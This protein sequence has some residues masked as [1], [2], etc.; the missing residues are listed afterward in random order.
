M[1]TIV[2][3]AGAALSLCFE[4]SREISE[5]LFEFLIDGE[6]L[7]PML[8]KM[9]ISNAFISGE[10]QGKLSKAESIH[11]WNLLSTL[12]ITQLNDSPMQETINLLSL[13]RDSGLSVFD[14]EYLRLALQEGIP[15]VTADEE[16]RLACLD[17]GVDVLPG[18]V[19]LKS[20]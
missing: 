4:G 5:F 14:A 8:W 20:F 2:L 11:Y 13:A 19:G 17:C 15:L 1:N 18:S 7:V 3:D 6:A 12:P 10:R 9:E 16:L